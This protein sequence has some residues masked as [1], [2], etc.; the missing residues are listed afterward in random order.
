MAATQPPTKRQKVYYGVPV[1]QQPTEAVPH[2]VVQFVNEQDDTPIAPAIN[3]PA[4]VARDRLE[5]LVN[6]LHTR[7]CGVSR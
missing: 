6:Q 5:A 7:V 4:N 3:L 2:V 1:P